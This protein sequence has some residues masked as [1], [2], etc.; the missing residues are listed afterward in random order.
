MARLHHLQPPDVLQ[1]DGVAVVKGTSRELVGARLIALAQS[2]M[3]GHCCEG[4]AGRGGGVDA[5]AH[6]GQVVDRVEVVADIVPH[7]GHELVGAVAG[8][9]GDLGVD[10]WGHARQEKL[11]VDVVDGR[12]GAV[13]GVGDGVAVA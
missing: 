8:L 1:L 9:S 5:D 7:L 6:V 3:H 4:H 11:L 10:V 13:T 12:E 2:T